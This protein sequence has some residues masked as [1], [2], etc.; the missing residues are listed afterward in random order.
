MCNYRLLHALG[1]TWYLTMSVC[2]CVCRTQ[3]NSAGR[4]CVMP[5]FCSMLTQ[6]S[7]AG[8]EIFVRVI[9]SWWAALLLPCMLCTNYN[10]PGYVRHVWHSWSPHPNCSVF[11]TPFCYAVSLAHN[12]GCLLPCRSSLCMCSLPCV[13]IHARWS[14]KAR[15]SYGVPM[16]KN[17]HSTSA[18]NSLSSAVACTVFLQVTCGTCGH[19]LHFIKNAK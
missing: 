9:P 16:S 13:R 18:C 5:N 11:Q 7:F 2:L 17:A 3:T 6:P 19:Q 12:V 15:P 10:R 14:Y 4:P 8:E 1:T